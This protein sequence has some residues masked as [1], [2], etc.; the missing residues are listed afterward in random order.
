[1][2]CASPLKNYRH[3]FPN[4]SNPIKYKHI[5]HS[6]SVASLPT[7]ITNEQQGNHLYYPRWFSWIKTCR[8]N[9]LLF[10]NNSK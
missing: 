5:L 3:T 10:H 9:V 7:E 1:M 8:K 2:N 6:S 4:E